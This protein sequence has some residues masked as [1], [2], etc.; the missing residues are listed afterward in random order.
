MV[1]QPCQTP[2]ID[3]R[4]ATYRVVNCRSSVPAVVCCAVSHCRLSSSSPSR[5]CGRRTPANDATSGAA[6][7]SA[8]ACELSAAEPRSPADRRP[9]GG[10]RSRFALGEPA[11]GGERPAGERG[12][13][14]RSGSGRGG[15]SPPTW[16]T[17]F[18]RRCWHELSRERARGGGGTLQHG[19]YDPR[20]ERALDAFG[21]PAGAG[22]TRRNSAG[23][24]RRRSSR[25]PP[26]SVPE[27]PSVVELL[28]RARGRG[29][30]VQK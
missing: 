17:N 9:L 5:R 15:Q 28:A 22:D 2:T 29:A 12:R 6:V 16:C 7:V 18:G 14:L 1:L 27:V 30:P 3:C 25:R 4:Q 19:A 21:A 11:A 20:H 13:A 23:T 26:P 8:A 10:P 24:R